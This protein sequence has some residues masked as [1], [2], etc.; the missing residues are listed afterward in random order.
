MCEGVYAGWGRERMCVRV[1][2]GYVSV[3][4]CV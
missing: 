3:Y 1:F 4:V 2:A